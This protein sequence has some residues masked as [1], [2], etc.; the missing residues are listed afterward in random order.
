MNDEAPARGQAGTHT[1]GPWSAVFETAPRGQPVPYYRGLVCILADG[2]HRLSVVADNGPCA[3]EQWQANAALIA[4]APDLLSAL[5]ELLELA[6]DMAA[7]I[8]V[9]FAGT[10]ISDIEDDPAFAKSRAAITK[11]TARRGSS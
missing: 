9:S 4:S 2:D 6:D 1:A 11:A 8:G 7:Q 3:P 5:T 10:S